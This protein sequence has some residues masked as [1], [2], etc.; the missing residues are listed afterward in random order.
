MSCVRGEGAASAP[1]WHRLLRWEAYL[2]GGRPPE[3]LVHSTGEPEEICRLLLPTQPAAVTTDD[4]RDDGR[5]DDDGNT[6]EAILLLRLTLLRRCCEDDV[7]SQVSLFL[8]SIY[9]FIYLF[10]DHVIIQ[11]DSVV[12]RSK[13][14]I[15]AQLWADGCSMQWLVR[16]E[17]P[18]VLA[19][20][21]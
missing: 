16:T 8:I 3:V 13:A 15:R 7:A 5:D 20:I 12:A 11:E 1:T 21:D 14:L 10:A 4:G 9:L 19:M 2:L 18:S 6:K 17:R